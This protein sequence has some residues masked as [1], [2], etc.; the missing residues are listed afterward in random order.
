MNTSPQLSLRFT[1]FL[2]KSD[3]KSKSFFLPTNALMDSPAYL[4]EL[5]HKR[6][7]HGSRRDNDNLLIG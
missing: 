2:L 3:V 6:P 7:D 1:G 5:L 4:E